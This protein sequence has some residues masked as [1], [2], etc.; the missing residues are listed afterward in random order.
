MRKAPYYGLTT[1]LIDRWYPSDTT[2]RTLIPFKECLKLHCKMGV[3]K[4]DIVIAV[5]CDTKESW[6]IAHSRD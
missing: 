5:T 6:L 4:P 1:P 3:I 2:F